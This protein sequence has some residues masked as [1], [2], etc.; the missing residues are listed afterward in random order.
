MFK[1][2]V[3][4][5]KEIYNYK[6][7]REALEACKS[8]VCDG[9]HSVLDIFDEQGLR[10]SKS[11]V[12]IEDIA[13]FTYIVFIDYLDKSFDCFCLDKKEKEDFI[14]KTLNTYGYDC[15]GKVLTYYNG[16]LVS[17]TTLTSHL[18]SL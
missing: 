2:S 5:D 18:L 9:V 8:L 14:E 11:I 13:I 10:K 6:S 17:T 12:S 16:C 1:Y 7:I 15:K 4:T 3:K